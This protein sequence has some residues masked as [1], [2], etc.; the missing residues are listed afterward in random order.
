MP[1]LVDE[2]VLV[3]VLVLVVEESVDIVVVLVVLLVLEIVLVVA[4]GGC[5]AIPTSTQGPK[6]AEVE[7]TVAGKKVGEF[8]PEVAYS[9]YPMPETSVF[10]VKPLPGVKVAPV[11]R[12]TNSDNKKEPEE[13]VALFKVDTGHG[14]EAQVSE[15]V[16]VWADEVTTPETSKN[17]A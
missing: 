1:V 16:A 6:E 4:A 8:T 15:P 5:R 2:L 17:S 12:N 9:E 10:A 13:K 3:P 11:Y 7:E 14:N